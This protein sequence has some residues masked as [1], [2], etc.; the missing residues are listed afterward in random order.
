[1][2][3]TGD[4]TSRDQRSDAE[5][6]EALHFDH[7]PLGELY[8]RYAG[9]VYGLAM[10]ILQD[11]DEAQDITQEIFVGLSTKHAYDPSRGALPAYL[12]SMTRSRAIDRLRTRKRHLR[13]LQGW[14]ESNPPAAAPETPQQQVSLLQRRQRVRQAL[15]GLAQRER[16]V[17]ELAYYGDL[18]QSEIAERLGAPLGSVKSWARRGLLRMQNSLA[19]VGAAG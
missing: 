14:S 17:I 1:M 9:L 16:E 2:S 10:R 12:A 19:D 18:S 3:E 15:D 11:G 4:E 8:D 5:L 7:E 13:L 6:L